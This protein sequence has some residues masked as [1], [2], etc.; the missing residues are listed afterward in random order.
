MLLPP[1]SCQNSKWLPENVMVTS[2]SHESTMIV[3]LN[4]FKIQYWV[5]VSWQSLETRMTRLD[6]RNFR[7]SR[8]E[9]RA[10]SFESRSS[11]FESR[12]SSFEMRNKE[13]FTRL[14]FHATLCRMAMA[15]I[16][17]TLNTWQG[18]HANEVASVALFFIAFIFT[19]K[20][21]SL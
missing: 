7:V 12:T 4:W 17:G 16:S 14:I 21:I 1:P 11:S 18:F 2:R 3:D 8:V 19:F 15:V 10:W 13:F 6:P 9:S 20:M 5:N